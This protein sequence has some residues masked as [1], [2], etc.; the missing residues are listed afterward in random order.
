MVKYTYSDKSY[1]KLLQYFGNKVEII[2][3]IFY[4]KYQG[5]RQV[6]K[7]NA[8][9]RENKDNI[10]ENIV[11]AQTVTAFSYSVKETEMYRKKIY[12]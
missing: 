3:T 6:P 1:Y 10:R 11:Y 7:M 12:N 5:Q 9:F 4:N 2:K 8:P